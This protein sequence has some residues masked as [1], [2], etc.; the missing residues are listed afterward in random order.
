[1]TCRPSRQCGIENPIWEC[2]VA[3]DNDQRVPDGVVGELLVRPR[4]PYVMQMGYWRNAEATVNTWRNLWFHTGDYLR[5][6]AE[7]WFEF[8]DRKKDAMRRFGENISSFE[9]ESALLSHDAVEEVAVYAVPANLSEDEV[10]ATIVL[11]AGCTATAAELL[12]HCELELPYYAVPRYYRIVTELPRTQTAK[13]QKSELRQIGIDAS[14][15]DGGPRGRSK[16]G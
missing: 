7:G 16:R 4:R 2:Y 11:K 14:T 5:R 9:V 6:D 13:V 8:I 15:W 1:M 10:M 12:K 3:D